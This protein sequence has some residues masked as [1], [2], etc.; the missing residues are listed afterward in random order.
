MKRMWMWA[1]IALV[2]GILIMGAT[3]TCGKAKKPVGP[4]SSNRDAYAKY[5]GYDPDIGPA[6]PL[7]S[8]AP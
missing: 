6:P 7:A 2:V 8:W 5:Y 3:R 4:W 1:G